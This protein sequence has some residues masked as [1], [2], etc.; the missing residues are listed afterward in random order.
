MKII[1]KLRYVWMRLRYRVHLLV[2]RMHDRLFARKKRYYKFHQKPYAK[3]VVRGLKAISVVLILVGAIGLFNMFKPG[4]AWAA[5][6]YSWTQ[7]DWTCGA[8]TSNFPVHPTNQAT[9][10]KYFSKDSSVSTSTAGTVTLNSGSSAFTDNT[11]AG[12]NAGTT[13]NVGVNANQAL[14]LKPL[15]A[16]AAN[17]WE[18]ASAFVSGGVCFNAWLTITL[19][20]TVSP[21]TFKVSLKLSHLWLRDFQPKKN[22]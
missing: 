4:N 11:T 22:R 13:N 8:D 10:C 2:R 6:V 17:A 3:H 1:K 16:T 21:I 18:C 14:L 5:S 9:W 15:G 19:K 7:T 12:F 20:R